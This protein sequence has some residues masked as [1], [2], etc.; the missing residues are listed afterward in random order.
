MCEEGR[1]GKR[2][3]GGRGLGGEKREGGRGER[4][5]G[6]LGVGREDRGEEGRKVGVEYEYLWGRKGRRIGIE[7][8]EEGE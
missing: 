3:D 6:G 5:G 4:G 2:G 8:D 7:E 1:E